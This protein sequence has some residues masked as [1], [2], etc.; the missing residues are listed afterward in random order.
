M[1]LNQKK[2]TAK[3]LLLFK[4]KGETP[5][6]A[7]NRLRELKP[8]LKAEKLTYAGRLDPLSSGLLLVL[9]GRDCLTK[10]DYLNLPKIYEVEVLFGVST[11]T[12]DILGKTTKAKTISVED[13]KELE[14]QIKDQLGNFVGQ[15]YQEYPRYSS[16]KLAGKEKFGKEIEISSLNFLSSRILLA[17]KLQTEIKNSINLVVGDFRQKEILLRWQSFFKRNKSGNFFLVKL[18]IE[19]SS[20]TYMR[21]LAERIGQSLKLPALAFSIHRI[22]VGPYRLDSKVVIK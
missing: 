10:N 19:A 4:Q 20:G 8:K 13:F 15:F 14:C 5:L 18:R 21:L 11:D 9:A 7:L 12:G 22:S 16:P 17:G 2:I 3:P 6:Q 1:V